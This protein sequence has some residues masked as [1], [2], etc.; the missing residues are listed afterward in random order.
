VRLHAQEK[1]A[2]AGA[3]RAAEAAYL[4]PAGL[5][6]LLHGSG[7]AGAHALPLHLPQLLQVLRLGLL[8]L[9]LALL[10][11]RLR[12]LRR[13]GLLGLRLLLLRLLGL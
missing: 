2:L 8:A 5:P 12:R 6:Q 4:V 13:S 7:D 11:R 10:L 3:H 9:L 1:A